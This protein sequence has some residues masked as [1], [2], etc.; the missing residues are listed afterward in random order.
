MDMGAGGEGEGEG[1]M[2]WEIRIDYINTLPCV[3]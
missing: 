3:K 1:G 2:K